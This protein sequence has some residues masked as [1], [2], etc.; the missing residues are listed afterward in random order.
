MLGR[1]LIGVWMEGF[2]VEMDSYAIAFLRP[3]SSG[4]GKKEVTRWGLFL[5]RGVPFFVFSFHEPEFWVFCCFE[6]C[7]VVR[8]EAEG[9]EMCPV[10]WARLYSK[11][12]SMMI[13]YT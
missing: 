6:L 9:G 1:G 10:K 4:W 8:T 7:F 5:R 11:L 2:F 3:Y 12:C 13:Q